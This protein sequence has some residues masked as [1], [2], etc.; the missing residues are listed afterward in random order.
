MQDRYVEPALQGTASRSFSS[1]PRNLA[2]GSQREL[3]PCRSST[4]SR[5]RQ[6]DF[7]ELRPR[8]GQQGQVL[9]EGPLKD[10]YQPLWPVVSARVNRD[11]FSLSN[12]LSTPLLTA[13]K[14]RRRNADTP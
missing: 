7:V 8:V 5:G 6:A 14:T 10:Q 4:R 13:C 2:V 1:E 11:R 9:D 3:E 12:A